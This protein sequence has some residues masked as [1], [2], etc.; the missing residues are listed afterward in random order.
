MSKILECPFFEATIDIA[1]SWDAQPKLSPFAISLIGGDG[2]LRVGG[3]G[4]A[5]SG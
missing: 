2:N 4:G 5:A 3:V 1:A